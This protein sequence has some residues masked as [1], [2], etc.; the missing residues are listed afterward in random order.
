MKKPKNCPSVHFLKRNPHKIFIKKGGFVILKLDTFGK[1]LKNHVKMVFLNFIG[2][3]PKSFQNFKP[4]RELC[5]HFYTK[6]TKGIY[7]IH[8]IEMFEKK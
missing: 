8:N 4:I 6:I 2:R 1:F 3:V 5:A 7:M